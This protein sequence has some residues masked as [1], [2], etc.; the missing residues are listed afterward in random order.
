MQILETLELNWYQ[1]QI[2]LVLEMYCNTKFVVWMWT[3]LL[4]GIYWLG[5]YQFMF[6]CA[7]QEIDFSHLRHKSHDPGDAEDSGDAASSSAHLASVEDISERA[8][9]RGVSRHPGGTED[10]SER[11]P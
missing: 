6:G 4:A 10:G 11:A 8:P 9:S 1:Y 7:H 2:K 3:N 5:K